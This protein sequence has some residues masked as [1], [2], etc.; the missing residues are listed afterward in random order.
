MPSADVTCS[1]TAK[2]R[3]SFGQGVG[4]N[5]SV[6]I[7]GVAQRAASSDRCSTAAIGERTS[8]NDK[9]DFPD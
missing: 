2:S 9:K 4:K 1:A 3:S 5:N 7:D 6:E 8:R